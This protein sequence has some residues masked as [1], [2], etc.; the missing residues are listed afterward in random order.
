[1]QTHEFCPRTL[2]QLNKN[3]VVLLSVFF[4]DYTTQLYRDYLMES[5]RFFFVAHDLTP[6]PKL[7]RLRFRE[8]PRLFQKNPCFHQKLNGTL[9]T[10]P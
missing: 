8:I 6:D 2:E 3:L 10:D 9:P 5:R 1:M 4:G 7:G